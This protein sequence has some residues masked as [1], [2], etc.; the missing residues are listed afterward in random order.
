MNNILT[1]KL[2]EQLAT[3]SK[4]EFSDTDITELRRDLAQMLV[5]VDQLSELNT[6]DTL[7]L[8]HFPECI[9]QLDAVC[10]ATSAS[11]SLQLREDT[12]YQQPDS[13]Q[14]VALA[15]KQTD[16]YYIVPNTF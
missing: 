1:D 5:Y 4:L 16:G 7:P 3:L 2:L 12:P 8:T 6:E 15:P 13:E 9:R 11:A 10:T 14:F